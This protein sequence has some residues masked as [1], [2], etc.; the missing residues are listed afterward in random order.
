M[1]A[2]KSVLFVSG[3]I[4]TAQIGLLAMALYGVVLVVGIARG[5]V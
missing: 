1:I 3:W 4:I 2:I 5:K